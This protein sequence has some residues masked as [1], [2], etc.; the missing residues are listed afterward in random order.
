MSEGAN[1]PR[2]ELRRALEASVLDG[3]AHSTPEL[4]RAA[5]GRGGELP[6]ELGALIDKVHRHAYRV[7]DEDITALRA[8]Y[9]DD[10][11]FELVVAASVGG[12]GARLDQ[13]L[14]LVDRGSG[15]NADDNSAAK[16]G[17]GAA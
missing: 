13:A 6:V 10:Q 9:S 15:D 16:S 7:S 8:R 5:A 17:G 1:D 4:R 12:A 3:D 11:L 2:D 14:A